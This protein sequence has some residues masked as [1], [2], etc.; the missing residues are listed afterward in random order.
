MAVSYSP[1]YHF[2]LASN[3]VQVVCAVGAAQKGNETTAT[4]VKNIGM[5]CDI[6]ILL[7]P[8]QWEQ[9]VRS[10]TH[11]GDSVRRKPRISRRWRTTISLISI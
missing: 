6:L 1:F 8:L 5:P 9:T 10:A 3:Q 4:S 11:D 7:P 2:T